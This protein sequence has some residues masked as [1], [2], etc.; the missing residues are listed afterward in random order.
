MK[1]HHRELL[2]GY[3]LGALEETERQQVEEQ[4]E[5]NPRL[6]RKL[7]SM[8]RMLRPLR[9]SRRS[10]SPPKGLADRTCRMVALS[11]DLAAVAANVAIEAATVA[12]TAQRGPGLP[13]R[14]AGR[15]SATNTPP[16]STSSWS[17][18]DLII[19]ACVLVAFS[20][21]LFPAI[22]ANRLTARLAVCQDQLR[23]L[24]ISLLEKQQECAEP[25][26]A[27]SSRTN[28]PQGGTSFVGWNYHE[29]ASA[30]DGMAYD[31]DSQRPNLGWVE[32][33]SA[34]SPCRPLE[35]RHR[36]YPNR[37][38]ITSESSTVAGPSGGYGWES[39]AVT[40]AH[41]GY[42]LEAQGQNVLFADGRAIFFAVSPFNDGSC[43]SS[44]TSV[45]SVFIA[46]RHG[47][48]GSSQFTAVP[49]IVLVNR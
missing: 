36:N 8:K 2:L 37:E 33:L 26:P 48:E 13:R 7:A 9:R 20:A 43:Q 45:S 40:G 32:A 1:S 21:L 17:W 42:G 39:P 30:S 34:S 5:R 15:M 24:G 3:L 25:V 11:A 16:S 49:P 14:R 46:R 4:L 41:R 27:S 23:Q 12:R 47:E 29:N 6:R 19:A 22:Q 31:A 44:S 35:G 18:A 28:T 38:R 10:F